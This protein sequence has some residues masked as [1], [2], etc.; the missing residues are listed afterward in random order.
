MISTIDARHQSHLQV[1]DTRYAYV[2]L[3]KILTPD[4]LIG[5]P[6]SIRIL[7][8]NVA[9][10]SPASLDNFIACI[11][12]G[13]PA[14]EVPF[15]PNRLMFHDTTCLPALADF[16]GMRDMV[17]EM[18]GAPETMNPMIPA[19]LVIDHSVIVERYA[20]ADAVEKNL[21][22]DYRRNS[23]RYEF[24]KWAQKS[25]T[26]FK[27]VPPGTGIIH[28]VNMESLATVVWES[29]T[30]D[31]QP[32]LHPDDI[33]ATDSHTPMINAIGVLGWGVGGL[34]G[35][36]AM[37]GEP[38]PISFPE[39]VGIRLSNELRP[40]VTA[41][42]LALRI[43]QILRA[44]GVV[45]KFVEFCGPGLSKLSWAARGTLSNMAP[46]YGATVV[47]F[48][49]D[50]STME[51]MHLTGRSEDTI[52]C[53]ETYLEAQGL[54]RHDAL[55]EPHFDDLIELD[56]A[57]I[58]PSVAGPHQPHQW[59]K[60][61]DAAPSFRQEILGEREGVI[62]RS[63]DAE[64][65]YFE[66]SF[67]QALTHGAISLA[68]IT[69]CTNTANPS[70]MIQAGLLARNA[71][72]RGLRS[73]PWV[74]TSLSP[75][76]RVVADYLEKADL[77][78][79]FS[80]L[81]FDLAGFGC[82]TCIGNSGSLEEH[83]ERFSDQGL[84]TVVVL[85]GNRN[86]EGRVNP[87]VQVGYLASPALVVAYALAGTINMD[88]QTEPLGQDAAG[89]DVYLHE[90]M[91]SEEQIQA[92]VSQTVRPDLFRQRNA[93]LWDG[94]HHWQALSASGSVQF[95]WAPNSTYLRRPIYLQNVKAEASP[96]LSIYSAR[97]LMVLGDNVTTDHISPASA[98]PLESQAGQWLIERG[99]NP[100]DLNQYSTR[101]SNHEVMMRG[102]FV[103]RAVKNRL[104]EQQ[105]GEGGFATAFDGSIQRVY[106]AA[107]SYVAKDVPLVIFAGFNYGAGS[108]RDWAAKAQATLGVKAVVA[109]SF[110]RIHRSNLIGMGILPITFAAGVDA[111][112][113]QLK[114]DETLDF[115]GLETMQVGANA[116]R[117][118]INRAD[119]QQTSV[120]LVLQLDS[121]QEI[122]YLKEGGIL[123]YV[124]RKVVAN[125]SV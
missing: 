62:A 74:K 15:Y 83:M 41:T 117:L 68:A 119:G 114:G 73:K 92:L 115:N 86:F 123:P 112:N 18:G 110:E 75:G 122:L 77:L 61:A 67:G 9:R 95:P 93:M 23:E 71:Q 32:L 30:A 108:S 103:N 124:V 72:R 66:P 48:P 91:P 26:N 113:L 12:Q 82:M 80:A 19:V 53:I 1:G 49:F 40:G 42:D 44:K 47:F 100:N 84:K 29:Q 105:P 94:T 104:L 51:Y 87:R 101:R 17:A 85:S 107:L 97:T 55:P 89:N 5:L 31:G 64:A 102:A 60:L 79:D 8:E 11:R 76:S 120:P 50:D 20:E 106:D 7:L 13:A 14:C 45:G 36:A 52:A 43:T 33:V 27:V 22:I 46:E 4:E 34:E 28:Q 78:S 111:T 3:H 59:R 10:C 81:G 2:D 38:V 25:L 35:Q 90:L 96:E 118:M 57:A 24:I 70:Q 116:V 56:L 65:E 6:Y 121:Q 16:A 125:A 21:D 109:Q 69:S 63:S 54:W 88:I 98:I 37:L 58:E 39:V 99:E